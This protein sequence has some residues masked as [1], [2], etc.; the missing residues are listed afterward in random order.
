MVVEDIYKLSS[1]ALQTEGEIHCGLIS[2]ADVS[3]CVVI[4]KRFAFEPN[5]LFVGMDIFIIC[6]EILQTIDGG[7][8]FTHNC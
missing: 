3:Q 7:M 6:N 5:K 1:T 4:L 2:N 8:R